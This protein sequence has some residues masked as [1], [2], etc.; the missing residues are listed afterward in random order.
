MVLSPV[1]GNVWLF[2]RA[3]LILVVFV[4]PAPVLARNECGCHGSIVFFVCGE[5]GLLSRTC[6]TDTIVPK[7]TTRI[8]PS[9]LSATGEAGEQ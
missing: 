6:D 3:V 1:S 2:T 9:N 7:C 4:A 5:R 8:H